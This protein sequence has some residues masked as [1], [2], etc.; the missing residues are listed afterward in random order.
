MQYRPR[1][2]LHLLRAALAMAMVCASTQAETLEG[3]LEYGPTHSVLWFASPESGDLIGQVFANTSPSGHTILTHCLPGLYCVLEDAEA[4]GPL[5]EDAL[6][7]MP[8]SMQP[9]GW[10]RLTQVGSATMQPNLPM[11]QSD[12]PTRFGAIHINDD[13]ILHF[14]GQPVPDPEDI[15]AAAAPQSKSN[16]A[17]ASQTGPATLLQR[18]NI[19]WQQ[20]WTPLRQ[21]LLAVLGRAPA[22][23][24]ERTETT[25]AASAAT[26]PIQGNFS[27]NVAAHFAM[28]DRDIV[29]LQNTGGT[30]CP[31]LY[32][33]ATLTA[34]GIAVTPEFGSCSDIAAITLQKRTGH[35]PEPLLSVV[36]SQGS[37]STQEEQQQLLQQPSRYRLRDGQIQKI[38]SDEKF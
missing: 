2:L 1:H 38:G 3:E 37:F 19:W 25:T 17:S 35:L 9:S 22:A 14:N 6:R 18:I 10:W 27:L 8:F 33:F 11:R 5:D 29:L 26:T 24:Q 21:R 34:D 28:E 32:R 12:L 15:T 13:Q 23:A 16:T 4:D 31:A 20:L 36:A 7:Q 30:A